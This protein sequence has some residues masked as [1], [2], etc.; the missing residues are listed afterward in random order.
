MRAVKSI[1][2]MAG[3]LKRQRPDDDEDMLLI[4][5]MKDV[6]IPKFLDDDI[7]LFNAIVQDLFPGKVLEKVDEPGIVN[8]I[9]QAIKDSHLEEIPIFVQKCL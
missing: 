4:Q 1:L 2:S 7:R 5:A 3:N 8:A 9:N 6:N